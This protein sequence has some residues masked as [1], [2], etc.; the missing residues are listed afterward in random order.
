MEDKINILVCPAYGELP[1]VT[2]KTS[3]NV[4][5][6]E[7]YLSHVVSCYQVHRRNGVSVGTHKIE[8]PACKSYEDAILAWNRLVEFSLCWRNDEKKNEGKGREEN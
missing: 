3:T 4:G 7:T 5:S 8:A 2:K 6:D 1:T